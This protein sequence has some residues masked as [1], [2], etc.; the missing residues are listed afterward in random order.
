MALGEVAWIAYA[1]RPVQA[2]RIHIPIH[3]LKVA[4]KGGIYDIVIDV[5]EIDAEKGRE[6]LEKLMDSLWREH[7]IR[8]I[9]A[10]AEP[11]VIMLEVMG[12]PFLWPIILLLIPQILS[13][14]GI[15]VLGITVYQVISSIPS[16]LIALMTI[17]VGLIIISPIV[18]GILRSIEGALK[19][20]KG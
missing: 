16:W 2:K 9:Y 18:A 7:G 10:R 6:A 13:L 19:H 5:E 14:I 3:R 11:R 17:G 12:S 15:T 1:G 8:T 4:S 20:G